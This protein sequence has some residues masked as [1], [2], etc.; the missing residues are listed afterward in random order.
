M[1]NERP[2]E[3]ALRS[4]L[5]DEKSVAGEQL[6][7]RYVLA[8]KTLVSEILPWIRKEEP[9]LTDHGP[10]HVA[11]VLDNIDE[12]LGISEAASDVN[13]RPAGVTSIELYILCM[14]A[15]FH[16]VGNLFGRIRHNEK[17]AQVYGAVFN[18]LLDQKDEKAAVIRASR[19]HTG[20]NS[21]GGKDT[22]KELGGTNCYVYQ[23]PINLLTI[24]A[25][26]RFADE[27][28]EGP[29][30][31]SA[32]LL[33]EGLFNDASKI[34]HEYAS[35]TDVVIDRGGGRIALTYRID[36][37][38]CEDSTQVANE[39]DRVR[40]LLELIYSRVIKLDQERRYARHYC[41]LLSPFKLTT[42]VVEFWA[43]G[44]Q[45]ETGLAPIQLS[46]LVIP[47][48]IVKPVVERDKSYSVDNVL[49]LV[50]RQLEGEDEKPQSI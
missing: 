8:R 48:E 45:I 5:E 34:Y 39:V 23:K 15:L 20:S 24:G 22:L 18:G 1:W 3:L 32:Y 40:E 7:A 44:W 21:T 50:R 30:R 16:D 43:D 46:D 12:L 42:V 38:R 10:E 6:Y 33:T 49:E 41:D 27:L 19:A 31:T 25:V 37:A 28:A 11:N 13:G 4:R 26:V 47:G 2:I 14:A 29:Q 17:I 35:I 9:S 36:L